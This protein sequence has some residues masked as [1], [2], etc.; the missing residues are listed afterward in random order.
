MNN[1]TFRLHGAVAPLDGPAFM[2]PLFQTNKSNS[3]W[4]QEIELHLVRSFLKVDVDALPEV[5]SIEHVRKTGLGRPAIYAYRD[6]TG[7]THAADFQQMRE[8]T[9]Q[10]YD[11][12]ENRLYLKRSIA[13]FLNDERLFDIIQKQIEATKHREM[14]FKDA[15]SRASILKRATPRSEEIADLEAKRYLNNC[16]SAAEDGSWRSV[17]HEFKE[18]GFIREKWPDSQQ[19]AIYEATACVILSIF[20][21][22]KSMWDQVDDALS[23][24][25]TLKQI[26]PD[27]QEIAL[28]EAEICFNIANRASEQKLWDRVDDALSKL[29]T[30]K[31]IWPDNQEIALNEAEIC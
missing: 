11:A 20:A 9:L 14:K 5:T 15:S 21:G 1:W 4:V 16:S 13:R 22:A 30:L 24:L 12:L 6:S 31:Q 3:F 19:I 2:T 23:K 8:L 17:L 10:D 28:N 25:D 27:N 18:L 7:R 29:D 26:W